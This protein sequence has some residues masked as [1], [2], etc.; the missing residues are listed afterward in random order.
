MLE[1]DETNAHYAVYCTYEFVRWDAVWFGQR[2]EVIR[3]MEDCYESVVISILYHVRA[4]PSSGAF[5]L[6]V[7]FTYDVEE[8]IA[9]CLHGQ[10]VLQRDA[11]VT[12]A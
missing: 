12:N 8:K 3:M 7:D 6:G 1:C 11:M 2:L 5:Y 4:T 10:K 9:C